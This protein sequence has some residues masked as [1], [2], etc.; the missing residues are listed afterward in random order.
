MIIS[1]DGNRIDKIDGT[2]EAIISQPDALDRKHYML[3]NDIQSN[4]KII[5]EL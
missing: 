1:E 2:W 5:F 4:L 3:W